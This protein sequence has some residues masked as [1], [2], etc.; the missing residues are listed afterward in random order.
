MQAHQP[1]LRTTTTADANLWTAMCTYL[2]EWGGRDDD[3]VGQSS[4]RGLRGKNKR[5]RAA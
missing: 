2:D 3:F 4:R 1:M 5:T